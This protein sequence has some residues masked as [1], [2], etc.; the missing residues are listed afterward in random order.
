MEKRLEA[1]TQR[2]SLGLVPGSEWLFEYQ[3][4]LAAAKTQELKAIIDYKISL[5]KLER[6]QGTSLKAKNIKFRDYGF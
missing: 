4:R 5:A 6:A 2:Y 3:R 1:E